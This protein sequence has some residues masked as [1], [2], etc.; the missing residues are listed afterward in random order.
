MIILG[1]E[2][3]CDECSLALVENGTTLI[4]QVTATQIA[5]H[6]PYRGVVPELASRGHVAAILDSF[7]ALIRQAAHKKEQIEAIAVTTEPGLTG[8]LMVGLSFARSLAYALHIPVVAIN[9]ILAHL[10]A[11]QVEQTI[12]YPYLG[13]VISGGHTLIGISSAP[14]HFE[15]LGSTVDDACGELFD[16]VAAHLGLGYPGGPAIEKQAQSGNAQAASFPS[17]TLKNQ[18]DLSFSGLKSAVI[19]Q[20]DKFWHHRFPQTVENICAALQQTA[21]TML[22]KALDNAATLSRLSTVVIGGGVAAN[23]TLRAALDSRELYTVHYPSPLLCG[24]NGAMVAALAA[25]HPQLNSNSQLHSSDTSWEVHSRTS[26]PRS[27]L[28]SS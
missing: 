18:C 17:A 15:L 1:I 16:K 20:R 13:A 11:V 27:V 7:H 23:S 10:Y 8:S 3:S 25:H 28:I 6:A 4:T 9:H 21:I 12:P 19:H 26:F 24:D 22:V 14:F 2:S 5:T